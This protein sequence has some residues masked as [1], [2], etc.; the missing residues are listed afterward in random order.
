VVYLRGQAGPRGFRWTRATGME[1]LA[2]SPSSKETFANGINDAGWIAGNA[3]FTSGT[4]PVLWV[5]GK[6]VRDLGLPPGYSN[7]YAS[8]RINS[9]GEIL[10]SLVP[11]GAPQAYGSD[12]P[13]LWS[14]ERGYVALP[15]PEGCKEIH[16]IDLND[17]GQVLLR[18][19][20]ASDGASTAFLVTDGRWKPLPTARI[21]LSTVYYALNDRGWL[22]G[23]VELVQRGSP[24]RRG[25]VARP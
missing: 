17:L 21:G 24:N 22:A 20:R 2:T 12:E 25:F 14:E 3:V 18:T 13:F 4:I 23:Y 10:V 16:A 15:K 1:I 7:G 6:P 8:S 9:R 11:Q 19:E 5:P